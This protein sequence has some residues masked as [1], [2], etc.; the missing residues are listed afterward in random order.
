MVCLIDFIFICTFECLFFRVSAREA[1]F[2]TFVQPLHNSPPDGSHR[3][4]ASGSSG[5]SSS[6][7]LVSMAGD[8]SGPDA[9][10]LPP[11]ERSAATAIS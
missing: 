4:I 8:F 6:M 9:I 11:S 3:S 1:L 5:S 10:Q 2:Y 7:E